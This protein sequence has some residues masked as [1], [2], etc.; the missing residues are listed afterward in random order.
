MCAALK[1]RKMRQYSQ[2]QTRTDTDIRP[3]S[4]SQATLKL[5][6]LFSSAT[7]ELLIVGEKEREKELFRYKKV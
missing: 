4:C 5:I 3:R 2:A 7:P 6:S 1:G